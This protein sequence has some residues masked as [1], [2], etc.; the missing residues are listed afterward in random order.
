MK[1]TIL[2]A[3]DDEGYRYPLVN[4]FEDYDFEV[5][6][7]SSKE[8]LMMKARQQQQALWV[9]DARLPS[10][11]MEGL[12]AVRELAQ[13]GCRSQFPVIF[14]SVLPSAFAEAELEAV[15]QLNVD[16][17]WLEKPFELESIFRLAT[18]LLETL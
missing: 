16:F 9:I 8:D 6:E 13:Q 11:E 10:I 12:R 14:I 5:F 15:R 7:V 2:L 17:R 3:E 1:K 18:S 4:L